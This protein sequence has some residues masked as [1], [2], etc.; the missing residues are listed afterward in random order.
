MSQSFDSDRFWVSD[1]DGY[2]SP[3]AI[4]A[5]NERE[6]QERFL[7]EELEAIGDIKLLS[8][9]SITARALNARGVSPE[10]W[11]WALH[12]ADTALS[13]EDQWPDSERPFLKSLF[14]MGKGYA[15]SRYSK[16][17]DITYSSAITAT[18]THGFR[19]LLEQYLSG[20]SVK[21]SAAQR[22]WLASA[23][24]EAESKSGLVAYDRTDILRTAIHKLADSP[25]NPG[26]VALNRERTRALLSLARL[27]YSIGEISVGSLTELRSLET[28]YAT[29]RSHALE[30]NTGRSTP[31]ERHIKNWTLR[32][33]HPLTYLF[34]FSIRHAIDRA[35]RHGSLTVDAPERLVLL[36]EL[37]VARCGIL[38]MRRE[39]RNKS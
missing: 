35:L 39:A 16:W 6:E 9:K 21:V 1:I 13:G 32:H 7:N 22:V 11:R 19:A 5:D 27:H 37:A 26:A 28:L 2:V 36:N 23:L 10:E 24:K 30:Q 34:P 17:E 14:S 12:E 29:A 8:R 31:G 18:L 38:L 25:G 15:I 4:Q 33:L 3:S 20:E